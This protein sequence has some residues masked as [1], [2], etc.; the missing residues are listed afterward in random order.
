MRELGRAP[1][2]PTIVLAAFD[3]IPRY[4]SK[5]S[6]D[7]VST[8]LE[9]P[10]AFGLNPALPKPCATP[11]RAM[12]QLECAPHPAVRYKKE[13]NFDVVRIIP[14]LPGIPT[15]PCPPQF[16]CRIA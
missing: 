9:P 16:L 8:L 5:D 15:S 10:T 6:Q 4:R 7:W 3:V 11:S 1:P 14:G 2:I 12:A 13:S